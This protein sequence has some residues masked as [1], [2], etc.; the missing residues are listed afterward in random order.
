MDLMAVETVAEYPLDVDTNTVNRTT[1]QSAVLRS[2]EKIT[3][4]KGC[5]VCG[6][7]L[8]PDRT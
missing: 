6:Q 7:I 4:T 5:G 1:Q 2:F 8:N 3:K